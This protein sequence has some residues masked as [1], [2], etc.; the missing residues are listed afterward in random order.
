MVYI[1]HDQNKS[2]HA[3]GQAE[4]IDKGSDLIAPEK[5]ESDGKKTA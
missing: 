3:N 5:A 4:N 2:S 1:Q